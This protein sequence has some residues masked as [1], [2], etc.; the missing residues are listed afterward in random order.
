MKSFTKLYC[1]FLLLIFSFMNGMAQHTYTLAGTIVDKQKKEGVSFAHVYLNGTS[2]GTQADDK[3]NFTL[4]N[5]PAGN[6]QF[7]ISMVGFQALSV[8]ISVMQDIKNLHFDMLEN[9]TDLVEIKVQGQRDRVWERQIRQFE[10]EYL[11]RDIDRDLVKILNREAIDFDYDPSSKTLK[12][13][14][15][16]PLLIENKELGYLYHGFL[17]GFEKAPR[18]LNFKSSG[19]FE[20]LNPMSNKEKA[21]WEKNRKYAFQGSIRHFLLALMNQSLTDEGFY[22]TYYKENRLSN[23]PPFKMEE[24]L[25]TTNK[26]N[27]FAIDLKSII[28]VEFDSPRQFSKLKP[29]AKTILLE[30]N[31]TLLDP[32]SIEVFGKM[33]ESRMGNELPLDYVYELKK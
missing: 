1:L 14:A 4:K 31:G 27:I 28:N 24:V 23:P 30:S 25:F 3:G 11:G 18:Q 15:K 22:V 13:S 19:Y 16:E 9:I 8:P 32:Y 6:Y 26:P 5:V 7:L 20:A 2:F 33:S 29:M 10:N 21:K 17:L 12:A